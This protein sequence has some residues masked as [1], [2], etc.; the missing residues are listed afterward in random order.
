[1]VTTQ[2][3]AALNPKLTA[4]IYDIRHFEHLK[5]PYNVMSIACMVIHDKMA[6]FFRKTIQLVLDA[7]RRAHPGRKPT[8]PAAALLKKE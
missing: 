2:Q 4:H 6:S 5:N 1:M 7:I 3:I 8:H